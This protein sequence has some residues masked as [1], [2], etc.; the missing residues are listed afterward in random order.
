MKKRNHMDKT[1]LKT[2]RR[3]V[4]ENQ[5]KIINAMIEADVENMTEQDHYYNH[6]VCVS[7][8][9]G[10]LEIEINNV[11][12]GYMSHYD[13]FGKWILYVSDMNG[14]D[15]TYCLEDIQLPDDD[16]PNYDDKYDNAVKEAM[17]EFV[18]TMNQ[19]VY[20][21]DMNKALEELDIEINETED[22][23]EY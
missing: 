22:E 9:S 16:D 7:V 20:E 3:L 12:N 11:H 23:E 17:D 1:E 18:A 8:Y 4:D 19:G 5:A 10:T 21:D 13:Q 14:D 2:L 6:A 15:L